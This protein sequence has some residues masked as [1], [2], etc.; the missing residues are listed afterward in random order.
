M[1][2]P[3]RQLRRHLLA[4][5]AAGA[6]ALAELA[7]PGALRATPAPQAGFNPA[8]VP[9]D[10]PGGAMIGEDFTFRVRFRNA[11]SATTGYGFFIDVVLQAGG[12]NLP[13][14]CP[15]DGITF[16][17]ASLIGVNGGPVSLVTHQSTAP[18]SP[19]PSPVSI[20]HPLPGIAPVLV[21]AGSQLVTLELPFGSVDPTQPEG[22]VE[23]T[24][25]M[26]QLADLGVPLNIA[27]RGGFLYG[28]TPANDAPPDWPVLSDRVVGAT[29]PADQQTDSTAW[30]SQALVTPTVVTIGKRYLGWEGETATGPN[31]PR[32]YELPIDIAAGQTLQN[33]VIT[34]HLPNN[35]AF[36]QVGPLPPC[37][38]AVTTPVPGSAHNAPANDVVFQCPSLTGGLGPD[39][40]IFFS[41]FIPE[42]DADG[43][44]VLAPACGF[45]LSINNILL[46]ADWT[47]LDPC[48]PPHPG[49]IID[50][51]PADHVLTDKCLTVHK[52]VA[53]LTGGPP[54]H[55]IPGDVLEYSLFFHL[56]DFRTVSELTVVDLLSD[57]QTIDPASL[58]LTVTDQCGI[59]AGAIPA[60]AWTQNAFPCGGGAPPPATEL[61]IDVSAAIAALAAP[62]GPFRHQ[63]GILTGGH[64]TA[65]P[66]PVA[67]TGRIMYRT[68]I[69]DAYRCP[70]P[71][72]HDLAV[73]KDD[74]V[75]NAVTITG[76]TMTDEG[77][78]TSSPAA[79]VFV[80]EDKSDTVLQL[81]GDFLAKSVYA[82]QRAGSVLCGPGAAACAVLPDVM[83]GD[84]VTFRIQK[85]IPSGDAEQL[86]VQDWLPQPI[87]SAGG[88]SFTNAPCGLPA[89]NASCLEPGNTIAVVPVYS[90][91]AVTNSLQFDYLTFNS[92]ANLPQTIDLLFTY[93]VTNTPYADG[94]FMTNQA[95]E[96]ETNSFG[97]I[98]CQTAIAQ[99][100]LREPSLRVMKGIVASS[101]PNAV[102]SPAQPAPVAFQ[103]PGASCPR[104]AGAITPASLAA[105]PINSNV[106]GIDAN[107]C[108]TFAIVVENRGGA[109]A[110]DVVLVEQYP[111]GPLLEMECYVPD[112]S[113]LC[114]TDGTGA[115]I[116]F[117]TLPGFLG[118][119]SI[120]LQSPL[121]AAGTSGASIAIVT[122]D[123][124]VVGDI[125]PRCCEDTASLTSYASTPNGPSFPAAGFGGP[126]RDTAD[127]CVV[128]QGAKSL[129][130]SSE[131]HTGGT[132]LGVPL[133][134]EALAIG[135][136]VRY[137]LR[138]VVPETTWSSTYQIQDVLPAGLS[139][140]PGSLTAVASSGL[141][142]T[143]L[144][145]AV[146]AG[147]SCSG[148]A[149]LFD[150]G[151]VTNAN[152]NVG[153]ETVELEFNALVCNV[154]ANQNGTILNNTFT[155]ISDGVPGAAS[156]GLPVVVVEPNVTISKRGSVS[157]LSVG[158]TAVY[159]ITLTNNGTA[160][161]F[162]VRVTDALPACLTNLDLAG[163]QISVPAT[164]QSAG[165][166]IDI[167]IAS[168]PVNG[169]VTVRYRAQVSCVDCSRL[170]NTA[171]V[172]W[173]S[174]PGGSGTAPNATGS[175]TP[176]ATGTFDG[177]RNETGGV[178]DYAATA[179]ATI[180]CSA[181]TNGTAGCDPGGSF[182]ETLTVTNFTNAPVSSIG[183]VATSPPNVT[184]TPGTIPMPPLAPGASTVVTVSVT[185]PGA[186]SGAHLCYNLTLSGGGTSCS[187]NECIALAFCCAKPPAG[188]VA[189]YPMDELSGATAINDVAPAPGSL[190]NN[191]GTAESGPVDNNGP[192]AVAGKVQ[193][194]LILFDDLYIEVPSHGELEF[195]GGSFS[196]DAW[197]AVSDCGGAGSSTQSFAPIIDKTTSTPGSPTTGS[198]GYAFYVRQPTLLGG[199]LALQLNGTTFTSTG[200]P[201]VTSGVLGS[202]THVAVVVDVSAGQGQGT[203]YVDGAP[204]GTF[205]ASSGPLDNAV[206]MWIGKSRLSFQFCEIKVDELEIFDGALTQ[207]EVESIF[208]A[209]PFGKCR[210]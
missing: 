35:V 110:H 131:A 23:I 78:C 169:V 21:P 70:V 182:T 180:C 3:V 181:V 174:L 91:D 184:I 106:S 138:M 61:T 205:V 4:V 103:L 37:F 51:D 36:L 128:A 16:V 145:P 87:F 56:S 133:P 148:G 75:G 9:P 28:A 207:V 69:D 6:V 59:T 11:P 45:V 55:P 80:A 177:E 19:S 58:S 124:C 161:A 60:T 146:T 119:V 77:S 173:T 12:T 191:A 113:T 192:G 130:T 5:L 196:I 122:F 195:N 164:D 208:D 74:L 65:S 202:W 107:D 82:V 50:L 32:Q 189:W 200:T 159:T 10:V 151:P 105:T 185:G 203:F 144:P 100:H 186:V 109:P 2:R 26:S 33:I 187:T 25:H 194:A 7:N 31:F 157:S 127:L 190:V 53:D 27:V 118:S 147:S 149:L 18:C 15:C 134:Q 22:I 114:V 34:D 44:P 165:S 46:K 179:S 197:V 140:L 24:A 108:V 111:L 41:F 83:A 166:L 198:T 63:N 76:R 136:V 141:T 125:E 73:G 104:P 163:M 150:F 71:A 120:F 193:G 168:I 86:T 14:P 175:A 43:N 152:N 72:P 156:N 67:A 160:A 115:A 126:L 68:S 143:N 121:P 66:S 201:F 132:P 95:Q 101:N 90:D 117:T 42:L 210:P 96:C 158:S 123:A 154:P 62:N 54:G 85:T 116:P 102:F 206:P 209:G 64:A 47:P 8:A 98:F 1:Y 97:A 20:P 162:D 48:D 92:T 137:R 171:A 89:A 188:M 139:Y 30:I 204:A 29:P 167:T 93:E 129:V 112:F 39:A 81:V 172:A 183:I 52:E 79:T 153:L 178:N 40:S 13:K 199:E 57:G 88:G 135:E 94:L 84:L 17:T 99:V 38:T 176:G 155:I 170:T 49:L 142:V